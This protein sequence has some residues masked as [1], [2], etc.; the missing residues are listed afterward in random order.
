MY[1]W[2]SSKTSRLIVQPVTAKVL[3]D[4]V[5]GNVKHLRCN[6]YSNSPHLTSALE[7]EVEKTQKIF[8]LH[9]SGSGW[10]DWALLQHWRA[11]GAGRYL[12][13]VTDWRTLENGRVGVSLHLVL[14]GTSV[15][16]LCVTQSQKRTRL[17]CVE[18]L[19]VSESWRKN[20]SFVT[21]NSIVL[22]MAYLTLKPKT[23]RSQEPWTLIW[24]GSYL[25]T[26]FP[27]TV[28]Q[29]AQRFQH[30]PPANK[31][32]V[33]NNF[34]LM[35]TYMMD[36]GERGTLSYNF[37]CTSDFRWTTISL[38]QLWF[39]W[40]SKSLGSLHPSLFS[41][42]NYIT[43]FHGPCQPALRQFSFGP[44]PRSKGVGG[45]GVTCIWVTYCVLL[46]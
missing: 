26:S 25:R 29:C 7:L 9:G 19:T 40:T 43:I 6:A 35:P 22:F 33:Q 4:E 32:K 27:R 2:V 30:L 28:N 8:L 44:R 18:A 39:I 38:Q 23:W 1:G 34:L 41:Q 42:H 11:G 31:Y 45:T 24:K 3:L 15:A 14:C 36:E 17:N 5:C 21:L 20:T 13:S 16:Q 10:V 12:N 46:Y 37:T